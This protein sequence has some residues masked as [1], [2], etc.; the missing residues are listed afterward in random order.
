MIHSSRLIA[1]AAALAATQAAYSAAL[2]PGLHSDLSMRLG[3]FGE[4]ERDLGLGDANT[5]TEGY[6][7]AQGTLYWLS[8]SDDWAALGRLQGFAPTGE[9]VVTDEQ[10]PRQSQSYAA[11]RELWVEYR[12]ITDYPGEVLRMGLQ[13]V[14]DPDGL[15]FDRN[16]EALHW[17]FDT[18]LLQWDLGVAES[19]LTWRSDNSE[20]PA[21]L[22]D[23]TYVF[24]GLGRQ[25]TAGHFLGSRVV[26]AFDHANPQQEIAS[27][28]RDPKL[29]DRRYTWIDL[30]AHNG[31]Y[32][33]AEQPGWRY[34][35]DVS[36]LIGSREDFRPA[37]LTEP[38]TREDQ[39]VRAWA[40]DLGLRWRLPTAFPLQVGGGYAFGSG[41]DQGDLKRRYEQTGLHSNRSRFTG[42]RS[43]LYRYSEAL[44]PDLTNLHVGTL[45]VSIPQ[46]NW[47]ASLIYN[48][49]ARHRAGDPVITD[50]VDI[51]PEPGRKVL[52]DALDLAVA[53]YFA[54][55]VGRGRSIAGVPQED[56]N[57]RSNVRLRASGFRP[58]VA[59]ADAADD[60][61]R[62]TLELTLWF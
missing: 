54:N 62:V 8:P 42:T 20:P 59:Y 28:E 58:G 33:P 14:R 17:M 10:R 26:Y 61:Y 44:Q 9:L 36:A 3:I 12:A 50:G 40:T 29:S 34:T 23:R 21:S 2:S 24:G 6:A 1:L 31:F 13:R 41:S 11:L 19:L 15:W 25:W 46:E 53:Y 30:Y 43:Q 39:N 48:K 32:Q 7:D 37:T 4:G 52:G 27:N 22:R 56:D 55:P 18:T 60:Q 49:F 57:L 51:Q 16:I 47:D 5:T 38:A 35:A 45:Y